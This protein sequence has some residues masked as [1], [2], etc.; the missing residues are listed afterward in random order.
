MIFPNCHLIGLLQYLQKNWNSSNTYNIW[1][2]YFKNFLQYSGLWCGEIND[3]ASSGEYGHGRPIVVG[4]IATGIPSWD[5]NPTWL[6]S[7]VNEWPLPGGGNWMWISLKL[8][9]NVSAGSIA[10]VWKPRTLRY[11]W[12]LLSIW[13]R[14][15]LNAILNKYFH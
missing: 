13:R 6:T 1:L 4:R 3:S 5:Q 11:I 14:G 8:Q 7:W 10:Y 9:V 15:F 2:I 12:Y